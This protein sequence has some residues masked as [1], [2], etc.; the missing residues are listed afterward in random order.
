VMVAKKRKPIKSGGVR[1]EF[2]VRQN[3]RKVPYLNHKVPSGFVKVA[4]PEAT[5]LDLMG[6]MRRS[7]GLDNVAT[8]IAELEESLNEIKLAEAARL[9]PV[10]WAQRLGCL[11]H[12]LGKDD[13]TTR[14]SPYVQQHARKV[15]GLVP[16]KS[17]KGASRAQPWK[18]AVNEK[19]E[20]DVI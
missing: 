4:S 8:V 7:A 1:V 9:S 19:P 14:L 13:K 17:I 15:V 16:W 12:L 18:V 2:H 3:L 5:A 20:P 10:A 6:Y 11:L